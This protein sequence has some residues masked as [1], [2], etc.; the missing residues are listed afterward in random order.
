MT[1]MLDATVARW[2][3][4]KM[5]EGLAEGVEQGLAEGVAQGRSALLRRQA[6]WRFGAE[7]A[8]QLAALLAG[9]TDI[10]RLDDAGEW[11]LECDTGEALLARVRKLQEAP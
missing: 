4:A 10:S 1:A 8:D 5:A 3:E 9:V 2:A 6:A 11:L 7:V